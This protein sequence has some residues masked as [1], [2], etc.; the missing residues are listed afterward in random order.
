MFTLTFTSH[1][2]EIFVFQKKE[3]C[4]RFLRQNTLL[5]LVGAEIERIKGTKSKVKESALLWGMLLIGVPQYQDT[6]SA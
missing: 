4:I 5:F 2:L 1:R 3:K 6:Y